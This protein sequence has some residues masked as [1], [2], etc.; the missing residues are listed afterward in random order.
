MLQ[1]Q[2]D[3]SVVLTQVTSVTDGGR[4]KSIAKQA[5]QWTQQFSE[6]TA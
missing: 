4:N 6:S 2:L 3:I 5:V 1:N